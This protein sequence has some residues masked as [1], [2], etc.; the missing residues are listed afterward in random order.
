MVICYSSNRKLI[1]YAFFSVHADDLSPQ[2][3][4]DSV[5]RL[6]ATPS[7][8]IISQN[9]NKP[10]PN[11]DPCRTPSEK[12]GADGDLGWVIICISQTWLYT[13]TNLDLPCQTWSCKV[14]VC[15]RDK[16]LCPFLQGCYSQWPHPPQV[17]TSAPTHTHTHTS[18]SSG[19]SNLG[20]EKDLLSQGSDVYCPK[21]CDFLSRYFSDVWSM[22]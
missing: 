8:Q 7:L 3:E 22:Q 9:S 15:E 6:L 21:V 12:P 17:S 13:W 5:I 11:G 4:C 10:R 14:Y 16:L 2:H 20:F 18:P 1:Q 19:K